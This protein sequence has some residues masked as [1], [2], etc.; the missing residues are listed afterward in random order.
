VLRAEVTSYFHVN[1]SRPVCFTATGRHTSCG[2]TEFVVAKTGAT[3]FYAREIM[4][5]TCKYQAKQQTCR[6]GRRMLG[7]ADCGH[8][9]NT[10]YQ[11]IRRKVLLVGS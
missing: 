9:P 11:P 4:T 1:S 7:V 6:C 5:T 3:G 10:P 2:S 8:E